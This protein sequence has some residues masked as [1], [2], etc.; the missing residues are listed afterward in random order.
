MFRV[1]LAQTHTYF[2]VTYTGGRSDSR[3]GHPCADATTKYSLG[4]NWVQQ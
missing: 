3:L 2:V 4:I 1:V